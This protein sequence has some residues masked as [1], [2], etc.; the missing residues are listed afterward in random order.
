MTKQAD[1][2]Y[3]EEGREIITAEE[4]LERLSKNKKLRGIRV[5]NYVEIVHLKLEKPN[6]QIVFDNVIFNDIHLREIS[7][8]LLLF[9]NVTIMGQLAI[10]DSSIDSLSIKSS[11]IKDILRIE[12]F[13]CHN[14]ELN[15][16]DLYCFLFQDNVFY[17]K[18][19]IHK[20]FVGRLSV[21][22]G[23]VRYGMLIN[24]IEGGDFI[25]DGCQVGGDCNMHTMKLTSVFISQCKFDKELTISSSFLR[26]ISVC[27][28]SIIRYIGF[29]EFTAD[30]IKISATNIYE[31]FEI[32]NV[33]A[34]IYLKNNEFNRGIELG[35]GSKV[36]KYCPTKS[37]SLDVSGNRFEGAFNL[38]GGY[39]IIDY[40][41][42]WFMDSQSGAINFYDCKIPQLEIG[43][44]NRGTNLLFESCELQRVSLDKFNNEANFHF[45]NCEKLLPHGPEPPKGIIWQNP[46]SKL[47]LTQSNLGPFHL[48]QFDFSIFDKIIISKTYLKDVVP[49]NVDWF[50]EEQLYIEPL[51][52]GEP[53]KPWKQRY[54]DSSKERREIYRQLKQ[55]CESNGDRI[56]A[57][58]FKRRELKA[59]QNQKIRKKKFK[60]Y[61]NAFNLKILSTND[62][63]LNWWK[64]MI[65]LLGFTLLFFPLILIGASP[66]ISY[67]PDW[68]SEGWN[69]FW[70]QLS[71]HIS[72]LPQL[73]NPARNLNRMFDTSPGVWGHLFNELHRITLLFFIFQI[74]S[75]FRKYVK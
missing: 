46:Q 68:T 3:D 39:Y 57:L 54:K 72:I 35:S 64:P 66:D 47:S 65:W 18:G 73:F 51:R 33:S 38:I 8:R 42:L 28:N 23:S 61:A 71:H 60:D 32:K 11:I 15:T 45:S 17:D 9:V 22:G 4:F 13:T 1:K 69:H 53:E 43:G 19:K 62:H 36:S 67:A 2:Q 63:G 56:S 44:T 48:H 30:S 16:C 14:I 6:D 26:D 59:Y 31:T 52:E 49:S 74:I 37:I 24:G 21:R 34:R 70:G 12:R 27:K 7:F 29:G 58:E 41:N 55:A 20:T 40:I 75:A 50:T 25:F 5:S 10:T